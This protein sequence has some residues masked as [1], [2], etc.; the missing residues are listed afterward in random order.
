MTKAKSAFDEAVEILEHRGGLHVVQPMYGYGSALA[1]TLGVVA[2]PP[3]TPLPK[4]VLKA[5]VESESR[6]LERRKS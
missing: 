6:A 3:A 1:A 2:L 5:F 4:T